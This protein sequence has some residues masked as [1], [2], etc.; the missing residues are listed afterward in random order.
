MLLCS[1][2]RELALYDGNLNIFG[3]ENKN[4]KASYNI[5]NIDSF[6]VDSIYKSKRFYG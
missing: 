1:Y 3:K 2:A 5:G 6:H 4:E